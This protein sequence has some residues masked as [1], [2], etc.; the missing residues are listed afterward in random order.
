MTDAVVDKFKKLYQAIMGGK[1]E[2]DLLDESEAKDLAG[3]LR[4]SRL[5]APQGSVCNRGIA[6][7]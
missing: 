4:I 7:W 2:G 5:R 3:C 1:H 6:P